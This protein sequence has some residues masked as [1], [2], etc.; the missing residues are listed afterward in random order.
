LS[1]RTKT[2]GEYLNAATSGN[3]ALRYGIKPREA[4]SFA[5]V[6]AILNY[7]SRKIPNLSVVSCG[8]KTWQV[9]IK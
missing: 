6:F 9:C 8:Y 3:Q 1:S 4:K 5:F 7:R 2:F